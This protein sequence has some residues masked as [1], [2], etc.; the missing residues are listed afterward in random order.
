MECVFFLVLWGFSAGWH[1]SCPF[2]GHFFM[3]IDSILMKEPCFDGMMCRKETTWIGSLPISVP[4]SP[5]PSV[6]CSPTAL[7]SITPSPIAVPPSARRRNETSL[8]VYS[9][10]N[11]RTPHSAPKPTKITTAAPH[12]QIPW[13][14]PVWRSS[15][16]NGT[17]RWAMCASCDNFSRKRRRK[18]VK[19]AP[20]RPAGRE[21]AVEN[22][23]RRRRNCGVPIST[24]R[25]CGR[26]WSRPNATGRRSCRFAVRRSGPPRTGLSGTLSWPA[27]YRISTG[28]FS[29]G[30]GRVLRGQYW[31]IIRGLC[32][33]FGT[34]IIHRQMGSLV[35]GN[36]VDQCGP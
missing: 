24:W 17:R 21:V 1:R 22:C 16:V 28:H 32:P 25:G 2:F 14:P 20:R 19:F 26:S 10:W 13:M 18:S 11:M 3:E 23:R 9:S 8:R 6:S 33:F 27:R 36:F 30:G 15:K 29:E 5:T 35:C 12:R 31:Q 34:S 4:D 7:C